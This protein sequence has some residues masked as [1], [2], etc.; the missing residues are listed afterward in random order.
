MNIEDNNQA[1]REH[2]SNEMDLYEIFEIIWS[3][4][5]LVGSITSL[6]AILSVLYALSVPNI[7]V[8]YSLL[9]PADQKQGSSS[10]L[11]QFAGMASLAGISIGGESSNKSL[12][13]IERITSY[14]FFSKYFLPE[15]S[16]QNLVAVDR[17]N[18]SSNS[19]TYD[20]KVYNSSKDIWIEEPPS[21]QDAYIVYSDILSISQDKKTSFVSIKIKHK[22]PH[23]AKKWNEIII[24]KINNSMRGIDKVTATKS[25][26]FL[27]SQAQK[28]NYQEIK[29][30]I[31]SLQESQMK[32]LM[33]IESN[34]DYIFKVIESPIAPEKKSLPK[35]SLIAM[36]G[37]ILGFMAGL[38]YV[39]FSHFFRPKQK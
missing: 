11:D 39:L 35:R 6:A 28:I 23:I 33:L 5:F 22:S 27:N 21:K 7:Y 18:S 29:Q 25:L 9:A 12:E 16:L 17:W 8:S 4:K 32:S 1:S 15:I 20:N 26:E 31:S 3:K 38:V 2:H 30:A 13:A 34:E 19:F 37:T 10:M 24:N 36:I 14:E